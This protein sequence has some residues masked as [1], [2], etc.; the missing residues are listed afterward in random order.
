MIG[1]QDRWQED[2]FVACSLRDLIPEDHILKR[3]DKVLDLSWVRKEVRDLYDE[4]MGRPSIDPEAALR[5]MLAGLFQG[6]VHDRKLMRE[7]QVNIAIR[8]F[9]G[10]RLD[11]QLPDHSSLTRIRHRWGQDGFRR[12]FQKTVQACLD[13]GLI[14]GE[15][16]HV[17]ATLIRADVSWESLVE[18]HVEQVLEENVTEDGP[19]CDPPTR[20]RGRPRKNPQKPKK[21]STTDPDATLTTN[22]KAVRMEPNYKQ[23]AAVDDKAGV[24]VDVEVTTGEASEGEQLIEQIERVEGNTGRKVKVVTADAGYAHSINYARL[25][26]RGTDGIIPPQSEPKKPKR[27]PLRRFKYDSRHKIVHC[28]AGKVL[29]RSHREV[30]RWIYRARACD[31]RDCPLRPRCVPPSGKVRTIA[32]T[33]GYEA[34]LRARRRKAKG[35]DEQTRQL[36]RRHRWRSEGVHGEAKKWHG[37]GRAIRRGL[38]NV[39]IQAYLTAAVMNLKRLAGF[40][41]LPRAAAV[42]VKAVI[43][44]LFSILHCWNRRE[45]SDFAVISIRLPRWADLGTGTQFTAKAA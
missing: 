9:A 17:D 12:V 40:G 18:K 42:G 32:I 11:E 34:L 16:V 43:G 23:H 10:Y 44:R 15:T 13:A 26:N 41:S 27:I 31:C 8:W 38:W 25:E 7:A 5:L 45:A 22:N 20:K 29:R 24:I 3:V 14:D 37:L 21:Y 4:S 28:P 19:D 1:R 35:W 33:D 36:Y 2:L 30:R 39:A 6:I